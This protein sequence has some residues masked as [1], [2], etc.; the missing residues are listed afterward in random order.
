MIG[1]YECVCACVCLC[2]S[3]CVLCAGSRGKRNGMQ[4]ATSLTVFEEQ[5]VETKLI[6]TAIRLHSLRTYRFLNYSA[7]E[8]R[9]SP[10]SGMSAVNADVGPS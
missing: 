9:S 10:T 4:T 2:V 3:R 7:T 5:P 1:A 6:T 8:C